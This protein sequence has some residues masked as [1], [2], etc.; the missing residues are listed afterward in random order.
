MTTVSAK[1][2]ELIELHDGSCKSANET[3]RRFEQLLVTDPSTYKVWRAYLLQ[4]ERQILTIGALQE[5]SQRQQ[6]IRCFMKLCARALLQCPFPTTFIAVNDGLQRLGELRAAFATLS[7]A[8]ARFPRSQQGMIWDSILVLTQRH[9]TPDSM[10][11]EIV[12]LRYQFVPK[13]RR[14][15]VLQEM[16]Q[17]LSER[18]LHQSALAM[19]RIHAL[20]SH[21]NAA[22]LADTILRVLK[23]CVGCCNETVH[24]T[25]NDIAS[26][27][28]SIV[29]QLRRGHLSCALAAVYVSTG[30][31]VEAERVLVRALRSSTRFD[32]FHLC[33]SALALFNIEASAASGA[34]PRSLQSLVDS[35][36]TLWSQAAFL[37]N[38][39]A[40]TALHCVDALIRSGAARSAVERVFRKA[41]AE[42]SNRDDELIAFV[43]YAVYLH[44]I[45]DSPKAVSM[46]VKAA[47]H[48]EA[49]GVHDN[50]ILSDLAA[51]IDLH[52]GQ[53]PPPNISIAMQAEIA[54]LRGGPRD[55]WEVL[56]T[57]RKQLPSKV[58]ERWASHFLKDG[59]TTYA[60]KL[61]SYF[62]LRRGQMAFLN[63][64]VDVRAP[65]AHDVEL[66]RF[67]YA[68]MAQQSLG[69]LRDLAGFEEKLGSISTSLRVREELAALSGEERDFQTLVDATARYRRESGIKE[70]ASQ[71]MQGLSAAVILSRGLAL[72][73]AAEAVGAV[74]LCRT[75][76]SQLA[77]LV[78]PAHD[79]HSVWS[80]WKTFEVKYGDLAC[81]QDM[82]KSRRAATHRFAGIETAFEAL[83]S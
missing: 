49:Q 57:K 28:Q 46:L 5:I 11:E 35:E 30:E 9:S 18:G 39:N 81:Y 80:Y 74:D 22:A 2:R 62:A 1:I 33:W 26:Y 60:R 20:S 72:C 61:F 10:V 70:L 82:E 44:S 63:H 4:R 17:I 58:A 79:S 77:Q 40:V 64:L 34:V 43:G 19:L 59:E 48:R 27:T 7:A 47:Q 75:L 54:S 3:N 65:T 14:W 16:V 15:H 45:R 76:V 23:T 38:P 25:L 13:R 51:E 78:D 24:N 66:A 31:L 36:E 8:L 56:W 6:A 21:Q 69:S 29:D 52:S 42:A 53:A 83:P 37:H 67:C 32:A 73:R 55:A 41:V 50:A 68:N 12:K 71:S